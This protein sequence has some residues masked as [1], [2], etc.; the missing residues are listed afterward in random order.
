[1]NS[2]SKTL[3][4]TAAEWFARAKPQAQPKLHHQLRPVFVRLGEKSGKLQICQFWNIANGFPTPSG[5][6]IPRTIAEWEERR[7]KAEQGRRAKRAAAARY[8]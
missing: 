3:P 6:E 8:Q 2:I 1:M 5:P 4:T 7:I